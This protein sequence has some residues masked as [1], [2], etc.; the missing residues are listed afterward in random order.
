VDLNQTHPHWTAGPSLPEPT[1]YP[2]AVITPDNKVIITGGSRYYRG[3]FNSDILTCH[4]YIPAT[5][6][7]TPL[8]SPTV[9]RDYHSEAL[10]L[11]DGRVITL[12]GNPLFGN[13]ADTSPGF[14]QT[15][16]EIYSPPY[17]YH[18]ARPQITGGPRSLLRGQTGA[19]TTPDA[20]NVTGARLLAPSAFTHVTNINQRSIEVSM[21]RKGSHK[22]LVTVPTGA[23]L[24]PTQWYM[25][26]VTNAAGTPSVGYW[27]HVGGP[28]LAL[29][30]AAHAT[31]TA[32]PPA[33]A[34]A[35]TTPPAA[36]PAGHGRRATPP[37]AG[38]AAHV[39]RVARPS[40]ASLRRLARVNP[41]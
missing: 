35:P 13:K 6:K 10:L 36:A 8:A 12:G 22:I 32:P 15:A 5:N 9:G 19:F 40:A 16:I 7:L 14:F 25:L 34:A 30:P 3:E 39:R 37:A 24:V 23:G 27:V 28:T 41:W 18:G 2:D 38:P 11:P 33:A 1:R 29:A 20:K 31:L 21:V 17:L 4:L 26:F